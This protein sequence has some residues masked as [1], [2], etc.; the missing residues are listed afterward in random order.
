MISELTF[1]DCLIAAFT[2]AFVFLYPETRIFCKGSI[3]RILFLALTLWSVFIVA[4][5]FLRYLSSLI[6][7]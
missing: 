5:L 1:D 7:Q 6:L 4:G 3:Y 2:V